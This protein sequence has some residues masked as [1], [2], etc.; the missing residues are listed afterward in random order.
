[1]RNK[2]AIKAKMKE[3]KEKAPA[4]YFYQG[5]A[6]ALEWAL[7]EQW[8]IF[9]EHVKRSGEI[10][11]QTKLCVIRALDVYNKN[12]IGKVHPD[13]VL[14]TNLRKWARAINPHEGRQELLNLIDDF[15]HLESL[16]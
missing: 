1:M 9:R 12:K 7:N 13:I 5:Y 4:D 8:Y 15:Y 11:N 2:E 3:V 6:A 10:S 14:L 16:D